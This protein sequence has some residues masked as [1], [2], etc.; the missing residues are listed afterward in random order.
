MQNPLFL[1]KILSV[2]RIYKTNK[3]YLLSEVLL[4]IF[5]MIMTASTTVAL[6]V[7]GFRAINY[8]KNSLVAGM[9]VKEC[10]ESLI[11]LRD[12]N[13]LR[14]SYDK[15]NCWNKNDDVC[16]SGKILSAGNYVLEVSFS[17]ASVFTEINDN[18]LDLSDGVSDSDNPY[19][20]NY[21]DITPGV[22]TDKVGSDSDDRDAF[23]TG[24]GTASKFYRMM[25]VIN[26]DGL[27]AIPA[28]FIDASCTV[29]WMEGNDPKK[30]E[31]PVSLTNY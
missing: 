17:G 28:T 26:T 18:A 6:V 11:G 1:S 3:G 8:N 19:L 29:A 21:F 24:P 23:T 25:Q 5:I 7:Y 22:N 13:W 20:L 10:S 31:I 9:L 14:F 16:V 15:K 12:T 4:S 30:I 27:P 2:K